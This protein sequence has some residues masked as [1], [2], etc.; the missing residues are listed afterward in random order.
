MNE[1]EKS[2]IKGRTDAM[3]WCMR[4]VEKW[5]KENKEFEEWRGKQKHPESHISLYNEFADELEQHIDEY[6]NS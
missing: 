2:E 3:E 6:S 4:L 5:R 1:L